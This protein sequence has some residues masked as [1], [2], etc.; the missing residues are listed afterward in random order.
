MNIYL[1]I[2]GVLLANEENLSLG[3]ADFI[4][5]AADHFEVYWLTT[6][7][8]DGN[9]THAI[10]YVQRVANENLRPWL[11]KFKPLTW[12][13]K[14]TDAIDFSKPFL[15][16]DDDCYIGEKMDLQEYDVLDS[17]IE[18]NLVKHPDQMVHELKL[19]QSIISDQ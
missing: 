16:F 17:W 8:M 1:D 5:Y 19:L 15:W 11:E 6:H 4:K 7:C 2:D 10:D 14:K 9:T 13:L 18:V 3:V 12:S